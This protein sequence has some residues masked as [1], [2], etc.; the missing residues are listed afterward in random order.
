MIDNDIN[1]PNWINPSSVFTKEDFLEAA[2]N[3]KEIR[4]GKR[5]TVPMEEVIKKTK[6]KTDDINSPNWVNPS[7]MTKEELTNIF[8]EYEKSGAQGIPWEGAL[9]KANLI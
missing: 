1:S 3:A 9:K 6:L 4:S 5:K 2:K 7:S 8:N